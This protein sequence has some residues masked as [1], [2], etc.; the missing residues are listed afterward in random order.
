MNSIMSVKYHKAIFEGPHPAA[1][2]A[3]NARLDSLQIDCITAEILKILDNRCKMNLEQQLAMIAIYQAV[4]PRRGALFDEL[5][6]SDHRACVT[7][8]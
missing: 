4:S 6:A 3:E 7:G 2:W 1:I 8:Q 5:G